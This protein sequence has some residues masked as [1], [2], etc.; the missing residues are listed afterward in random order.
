VNLLGKRAGMI[1]HEREPLNAETPRHALLEGLLTDTDAFYVRNHGPIPALDPTAWRLEVSGLVRRD[2]EISLAGLQADFP[3]RELVA[4]L[5]CAGNRRADLMAVREIPGEA[6]W[7][8]GATGTARWAGASLADVLAAAG[9]QD[10]AAYIEFV[11]ADVSQEAT[12]PQPFGG[13]ISRRK[14]MAGE[15]LLAWAMN[16]RPVTPVH[17]APVRVVVPGYIGSAQRQ[18]ADP[19]HGAGVSIGEPLPGLHVPDVA[20]GGRR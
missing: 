6:P 3:R 17:G 16:G 11:A 4:T 19:D 5:Q 9:L 2:L 8:P 12:P 15:V 20:R 13:S 1:I 7:G 10:E 18:V 14:A